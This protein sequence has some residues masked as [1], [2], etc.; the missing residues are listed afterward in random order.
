MKFTINLSTRRYLNLRLLDYSL[1]AGFVLLALLLIFKVREVALNQAEL[2]RT[3]N[4]IAASGAGTGGP[5]VSE[6]Q[7]KA[8][9]PKIRFANSLIQ[10]KSADWLGL[11]DHLEEV[12]PNGVAMTSIEPPLRDSWLK[13]SGSALTFANLRALLENM[14]Q[15]RYFSEVYLMSQADATVGQTQHGITFAITCKVPQR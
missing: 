10:R 8:L 9:A 11:L 14:E 12:V 13:L 4:L 7:L 5:V 3:R 2:S 1:A 6:A 15:S